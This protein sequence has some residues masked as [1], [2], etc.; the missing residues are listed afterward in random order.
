MTIAI[1]IFHYQ[2]D[3]LSWEIKRLAKLSKTSTSKCEGTLK[4]AHVMRPFD[5]RRAHPK[6][7]ENKGIEGKVVMSLSIDE[8]GYV[9]SADVVETYPAGVFENDAIEVAKKMLYYPATNNCTP[10]AS[11]SKLTVFYKMED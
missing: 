4:K 9:T 7:A 8:K 5:V 10:I 1:S 11:T 3:D 6:I 2:I